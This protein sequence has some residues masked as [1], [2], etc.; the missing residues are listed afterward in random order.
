MDIALLIDIA[1]RFGTGVIAQVDLGTRIHRN[2]PL[3]ELSPQATA[4]MQTM[5]SRAGHSVP[6]GHPVPP[7][8]RADRP[9]GGRTAA[10]RLRVADG[11]AGQFVGT[12]LAGDRQFLTQPWGRC[13]PMDNKRTTR[14]GEQQ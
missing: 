6:R 12:C 13:V 3:D 9:R 4:V 14:S 10:A 1:D 2:R 11:A 7:R 8:P 5:L